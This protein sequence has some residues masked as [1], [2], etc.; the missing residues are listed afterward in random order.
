MALGTIDVVYVAKRRIS[1]VY[2]LDALAQAV[3]LVA[4]VRS[5]DGPRFRSAL[6]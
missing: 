2:L 5:V 1:P 4:W 6:S 3:L